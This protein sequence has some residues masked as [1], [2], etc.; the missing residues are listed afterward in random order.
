MNLK[1]LGNLLR[2]GRL[3]SD[4]RGDSYGLLEPFRP[5]ASGWRQIVPIG[6]DIF[7]QNPMSVFQMLI[8]KHRH[9]QAGTAVRANEQE[10]R[11]LQ[12]L[13]TSPCQVVNTVEGRNDEKIKPRSSNAGLKGI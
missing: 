10:K 11:S 2:H 8:V 5:T 4:L 9:Y 6:M 12:R 3:N 13:E 1:L 7:G